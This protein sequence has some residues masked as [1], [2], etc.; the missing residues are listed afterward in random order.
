VADL[1]LLHCGWADTIPPPTGPRF[2]LFSQCT[3]FF[4]FISAGGD[5]ACWRLLSGWDQQ[6]TA[7]R[8]P[9]LLPLAFA[10]SGAAVTSGLG[11]A[12]SS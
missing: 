5:L 9:S 12:G 11:K 4:L 6:R 8:H 1:V 2:H 3:L 10:C 7:K